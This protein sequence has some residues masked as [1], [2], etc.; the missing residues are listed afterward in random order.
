VRE[1]CASQVS[2]LSAS[3]K[4]TGAPAATWFAAPRYM[5]RLELY[6]SR[7]GRYVVPWKSPV[8]DDAIICWNNAVVNLVGA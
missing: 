3:K 8:V 5:P 4:R 6:A 7:Y 2:I 1:F